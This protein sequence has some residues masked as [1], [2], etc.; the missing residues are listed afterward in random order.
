ME[1]MLTMVESATATATFP[2]RWVANDLVVC[3][4]YRSLGRTLLFNLAENSS[5]AVGS[6][7]ILELLAHATEPRTREEL[8]NFLRTEAGL[9]GEISW[10][11]VDFCAEKELLRTEAAAGSDEAV[12]ALARWRSH[13]WDAAALY[14]FFTRDFPFLDY[15]R[16][17]AYTTDQGLMR[18]YK[19]KWQEP[20]RYKEYPGRPFIPLDVFA[21]SLAKVSLHAIQDAALPQPPAALVDR[22][23]LGTLLYY[24]FGQTGAIRYP[25]VEPLLRRTS[26]SGGARHPTE[27]YVAIFDAID[28]IPP[29]LYHYSVKEQGLAE[30]T[31]GDF[32]ARVFSSLATVSEREGLEPRAAIF[33]T[34]MVE[35]NMWRYREPRT[36]RVI[37]LD[38]GHLTRTSYLVATALGIPTFAHH[39]MDEAAIEALLGLNP[40]HES[41]FWYMVLG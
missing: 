24:T 27:G 36:Y 39:G 38:L 34:S 22:A 40:I 18:E 9:T 4:F 26:P 12:A 30:I 37:H 8:V 28:D 35:R 17:D 23:S 41:V 3:A 7:V 25:I 19:G 1:R 32:R 16:A 11:L 20:G 31:P 5:F 10:R 29:G 6:P 15:S 13:G 14:H 33:Y 21:D 2:G